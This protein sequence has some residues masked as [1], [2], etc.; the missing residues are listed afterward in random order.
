V[1]II[2]EVRTS[3]DFKPA[4][5]S[6][7]NEVENADFALK[8]RYKYGSGR[9]FSYTGAFTSNYFKEIA[10]VHAISV[11]LNFD[12][13]QQN[14]YNYMFSAQGFPSDQSDFLPLALRYERDGR[15][16]GSESTTRRVGIVSNVNYSYKYKY[17]VDLAYR[18]DG[19][20]QFGSNKRFA[21]FWSAGVAWNLH[22][23]D[24]IKDLLPGVSMF[25]IRASYGLTGSTQFSAYQSQAIYKYYLDQ[26]YNQWIGSYQESLPNPN[27]EWQKT[28]QYN[29]GVDLN[30]FKNRWSITGD[31]Y[32]KYTSNLLS[33]L[34]LPFSNGFTSYNENVGSLEEKGFELRSTVFLIPN[35]NNR[36][37]WSVTGSIA[38][39]QDKITKLSKA[40]KEANT[41]LLQNYSSAPNKI[42]LE[43]ESQNMIY[44]VRSLG[45]DPSNGKEMFLTKDGEST[46]QWDFRDRIAGGLGQPK[47]R[48]N[49]STQLR[50]KDFYINASFGFRFGG[51][52]Y[53]N[54]LVDKIENADKYFNVDRR[55]LTDRWTKPGDVTKFRGLND[56]SPLS[57][58][59]RFLQKESTLTLQAISVSYD[60]RDSFVI[61]VY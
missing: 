16:G 50:Y 40:M 7:F 42:I 17:I 19:A 36:W 24:F 35:V 18:L 1:G 15:P 47:F 55:V 25:K 60:M 38:H 44:V 28:G 57:A 31:I 51:Y 3:D 4:A 41:R 29:L 21:P 45:I 10:G 9:S 27:L 54:T 23:E 11:G 20:S 5:H 43:G 2:S 53:N 14:G 34:D 61:V 52:L 58:S 26:Q 8:G 48:G 12:M 13:A 30:L 59:S 46:Y 22:R 39:T 33:S 37:G 32:R 6:M 56:A 49:F